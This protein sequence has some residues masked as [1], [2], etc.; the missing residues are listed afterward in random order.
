MHWRITLLVLVVV[1]LLFFF[2]VPPIVDSHLNRIAVDNVH[3]SPQTQQLH[4]TLRI[5]DLHADSFL[6]GRDL[7]AKHSNGQV[8]LPRLLEGNIGLETFTAVTKSPRGLNYQRN[9]GNSDTIIWLA[10]S[11]RWPPRTWNSLTERALFIAERFHQTAANSEGRLVPI[12]T[13]RDLRIFLTRREQNKNMVAGVLG[14]EGAHA[15]DGKLENLD[16]LFHAGYRYISLAHFFDDEF[17]GSSAGMQKGRL[18]PLGRQLVQAMNKKHIIIDLAHTSSAA[19]RDVLSLT[20]APVIFSHGGLRGACNN[21]RNL[22]DEEA[23]GIAKTGGIIGIGFWD[24]AVCGT[25]A[26]SIAR[27]IRY[28]VNLVGVEHVALGSDF[29]GAVTVPFDSAHLSELTQALLDQGFRLDEIRAIM[30]ENTLN[31]FLHN[32]PD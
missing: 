13:A 9:R 24:T 3:P 15:L 29:D 2:A 26:G 31:F 12:Q 8:D 14:I 18:T 27:S 23:L 17:A 4:N 20:S 21:Q 5:A 28:A 10:L 11:Q 22:T 6:W 7:L 19:I 16:P 25:D 32:L 30:G 1:L